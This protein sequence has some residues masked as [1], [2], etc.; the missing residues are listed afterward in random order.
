MDR[1][2]WMSALVGFLAPVVLFSP[3][4]GAKA[5]V[6]SLL[7]ARRPAVAAPAAHPIVTVRKTARV[8]V[9]RK[10]GDKAPVGPAAKPLDPK[11]QLALTIDPNKRPD[12]YLIDPTLKKGDVLFLRNRVVVFK[13]DKIGDLKDYVPVSGTRLLS[14]K[15]RRLIEGLASRDSGSAV[16][17]K[18]APQGA[19]TAR[20]EPAKALRIN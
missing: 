14:R 7:D 6:T 1:D 5:W 20:I 8:V 3:L 13:G 15:E 11:E 17:S 9:A 19:A 18:P 4:N 12:W 16:P 10:R 2:I